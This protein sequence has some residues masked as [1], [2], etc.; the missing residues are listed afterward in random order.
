MAVATAPNEQPQTGPPEHH[1]S[2]TRD[3]IETA[4]PG[5][6]ITLGRFRPRA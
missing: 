5:A 6:G 3:S 4:L 2:G 1:I